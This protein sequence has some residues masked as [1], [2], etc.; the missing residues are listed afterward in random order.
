MALPAGSPPTIE[1]LSVAYS[2]AQQAVDD[3]ALNAAWISVQGT[4]FPRRRTDPPP[5]RK[6]LAR[7]RKIIENHPHLLMINGAVTQGV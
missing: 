7:R 3:L 1:T 5:K 6:I 2:E 4:D